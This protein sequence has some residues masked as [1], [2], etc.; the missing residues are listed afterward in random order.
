MG[1]IMAHEDEDLRHFGYTIYDKDFEYSS[2]YSPTL[3]KEA[4]L[5]QIKL[6]LIRRK[7]LLMEG[8]MKYER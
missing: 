3:L 1:K 5:K 6:E 4:S 7:Q 2:T 8:K